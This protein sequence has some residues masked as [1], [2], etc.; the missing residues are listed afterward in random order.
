MNT[1]NSF[2]RAAAIAML[3]IFALGLLAAG[4]GSDDNASETETATETVAQTDT[5]AET[6]QLYRQ[7]AD[8][9]VA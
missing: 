9:L 2:H 4:C 3:A 8:S 7:A 6:K 1:E 5:M